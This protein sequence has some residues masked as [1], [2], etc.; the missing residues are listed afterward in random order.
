[1]AKDPPEPKRDG[2][3]AHISGSR[4]PAREVQEP[5]TIR[6]PETDHGSMPNLKWSF[7]D[8]HVRIEK[9]G[10]TRETTIRELPIAKDVSGVNMRLEAGGV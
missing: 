7:A 5:F 9:S 8:S 3:G 2:K 10:W 4:K 6:P 1:M